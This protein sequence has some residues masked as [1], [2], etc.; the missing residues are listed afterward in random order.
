MAEIERKEE[1]IEEIPEKEEKIYVASQWKLMWWR[2]R[3]NKLAI[4]G[5]VVL[6]IFY[7]IA[8]FCEFFAPY[9]PY[10]YDVRYVLAP[11][12]RIHFVDEQGIHLRP[13]VYAY[14]MEVDPNTLRR[15]YTEDKSRKYN[16]KFFVRGH[17]Y[18][19]L[20]LFRTNIHL[21]GVEEGG[22]IFL[23]GTDSLGRDVFSRVIYGTRIS[24]TVGLVGI[25]LSFLFGIIIGGISGYY[26]GPFDIIIQRI[27]EILRS[28]PTLPLW[29]ALSAAVPANWSPVKVYFAI[30]IILSFIGWTGLAREVRSKFLSLR[31]EDFVTAAKL[32]GASEKRIIFRHLLPSFLSHIIA[33]LTLSIPSM[34]IGETSLS[35]LGLGIRPPAISW[36]VLIQDAQNFR[37]VA[38]APWLL[39]PVLF[40]ILV[41]LSFNF[42]GDG[43]R[44]A[45][46]P[47][48][49]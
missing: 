49:R 31:E 13:F 8:A 38:L 11:P 14:K 4:I 2:F 22:H 15:I 40:V 32:A 1:F 43:L 30:S 3:R 26:G 34:I 20:G 33:S 35:F 25:F 36:G 7:I 16:I 46:D 48:A 23:F 39:L 6:I 41:V 10:K 24:T 12:Q 19:L 47:Y 37:T 21:F 5:L 29:M 17:E 42:V 9:D 45:A 27:I 18:K 44:D 28:I